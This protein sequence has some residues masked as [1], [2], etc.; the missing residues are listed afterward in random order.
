[1]SSQGMCE[2]SSE[3][4]LTISNTIFQQKTRYKTPWMHP[5]TKHWDLLYYVIMRCY[6]I[7]DVLITHTTKSAECR[8]DHRMIMAMVLMR[9]RPSMQKCGPNGRLLDCVCLE[10]TTA[11]SEYCH[12]PAEKLGELELCL[13][14][15]NSIDQ[16][17]IFIS[18]AHEA[19]AK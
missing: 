7:R 8:T 18:A 13:N 5:W 19:I 3:H 2:A 16:Q 6:D 4:S 12:S 9:V 1:M 11:I 14:G 17:W 10:D 15:E